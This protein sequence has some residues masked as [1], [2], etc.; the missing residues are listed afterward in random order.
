MGRVWLLRLLQHPSQVHRLE[1][2]EGGRHLL[3]VGQRTQSNLSR[4]RSRGKLSN[5]S[6][7]KLRSRRKLTKRRNLAWVVLATSTYPITINSIIR[8]DPG[9]SPNHVVEVEI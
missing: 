3:R 4:L 7:L 9:W 8:V 1:H 2:P 6:R 5:L